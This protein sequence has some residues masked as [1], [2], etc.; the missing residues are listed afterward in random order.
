VDRGSW[1]PGSANDGSA[2]GD[3]FDGLTGGPR[4]YGSP[5]SETGT[6]AEAPA[7]RRPAPTGPAA[8]G[9]SS[10]RD[11]TFDGLTGGPRYYGSPGSDT[12]TTAT[13]A[14][15]AGPPGPANP[16]GYGSAKTSG[17]NGSGAGADNSLPSSE[18]AGDG[19]AAGSEPRHR[20]RKR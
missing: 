19:P 12:G 6:P 7:N 2:S 20:R 3:A 9:G 10:L 17:V 16:T 15:T 11:S 5:G 1:Y 18:V 4:Y 13:G 8:N 14:P